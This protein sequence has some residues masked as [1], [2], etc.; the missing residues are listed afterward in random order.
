MFA[1]G[2]YLLRTEDNLKNMTSDTFKQL[3]SFL[4]KSAEVMLAPVKYCCRP[5]AKLQAKNNF[6]T[7]LKFL[8]ATSFIEK[9]IFS[10]KDKTGLK[11][12]KDGK[13]RNYMGKHFRA[14]Y[15]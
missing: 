2:L 8:P 9:M 12:K 10:K 6:C 1:E 4:Y 11:L 7:N 3:R 13:R 5:E 15:L 14:L